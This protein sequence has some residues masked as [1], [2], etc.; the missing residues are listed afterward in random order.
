MTVENVN[1]DLIMETFEKVSEIEDSLEQIEKSQMLAELQVQHHHDLKRSDLITKRNAILAGIPCFWATAMSNHGLLKE[2][3]QKDA[4]FELL[5]AVKGVEVKRP[6]DSMNIFEIVFSFG[7]NKYISN[8]TLTKV[9]TVDVEEGTSVITKC[10][11]DWNIDIT[12]NSGK[13]KKQKTE[14]ESFFTW[15]ADEGHDAC[16]I[17]NVIITDFCPHVMNYYQG[18]DSDDEDDEDASEIDLSEEEQ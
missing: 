12:G 6:A 9:L 14:G 10:P 13:G 15:F 7:D 3:M 8:S 2:L 11:I 4:D 1:E 17:A 16:S 5:T 18:A